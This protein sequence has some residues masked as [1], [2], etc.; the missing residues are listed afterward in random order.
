MNLQSMHA[1]EVQCGDDQMI[2]STNDRGIARALVVGAAADADSR[3]PLAVLEELLTH[4]IR[5]RDLY[6]NVR[7]QIPSDQFGELRWILD[8]HYKEQLGL[9]DVIVD[10]IRTLGGGGV[11]AREFLQSGHFCRLPLGPRAFNRL[12]HDFLDAHE[13]VLGAARLHDSNEDHHLRRDLAVGQ[14]V[15]TNEQQRELINGMLL[16]IESPLRFR[17]ADC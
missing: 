7:R 8:D 10:R 3:T 9:I 15:L 6:K 5:L 14:V 17:Q 11:F 1:E 16:R 13:S 12:L 2:G 4:S